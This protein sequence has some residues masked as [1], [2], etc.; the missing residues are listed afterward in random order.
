MIQ[1]GVIY[2]SFTYY[3]YDSTGVNIVY[4]EP[5]RRINN[6]I[7]SG[8]ITKNDIIPFGIGK[9]F[10][11]KILLHNPNGKDSF[12]TGL[13]TTLQAPVLVQDTLA[14]II[15]HNYVQFSVKSGNST[16]FCTD[17][18]SYKYSIY[19]YTTTS[20][21]SKITVYTN[22]SIKTIRVYADTNT[23]VRITVTDI[24]C[25]GIKTEKVYELKTLPPIVPQ[26]PILGATE[27]GCAYVGFK[28]PA[29]GV[30]QGDTPTAFILYKTKSQT[31]FG[32]TIY[33]GKTV[34]N[35]NYLPV[36]IATFDELD[37]KMVSVSRHGI[38]RESAVV[39]LIPGQWDKG[40]V[41]REHL[42]TPDTTSI[43]IRKVLGYAGCA[44]MTDTVLLK[45]EF[46]KK[47]TADMVHM[48]VKAPVD[49]FGYYVVEDIVMYGLE[50][51]TT[52]LFS[53]KMLNNSL[54]IWT[55]LQGGDLLEVSTKPKSTTGGGSGGGS[56]GG[57]SGITDPSQL[58]Q[59]ISYIVYDISMKKIATGKVSDVRQ[60]LQGG[61]YLFQDPSSADNHCKKIIF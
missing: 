51:G 16:F 37:F 46:Q 11:L 42:Y 27:T 12:V 29:M 4:V 43:K 28:S 18:F 49:V 36:Y 25:S 5:V 33:L 31:F 52:Y 39:S 54:G 59:D 13:L 24:N 21:P 22:D 23:S 1:S 8:S 17:T 14:T 19:P 2:D 26:V 3:F 20:S 47:G 38:V 10:I 58:D 45:Y 34:Q 15:A 6:M 53:P 30:T 55:E 60:F 9:K 44:D 32:D 57:T 41:N 48:F 40:S 7:S 35:K 50:P 56:G 61:L